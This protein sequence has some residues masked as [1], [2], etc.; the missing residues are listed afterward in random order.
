MAG[1]LHW[2]QPDAMAT[3]RR[4]VKRAE[5]QAWEVEFNRHLLAPQPDFGA[6][7]HALRN[8]RREEG[9]WFS[10]RTLARLLCVKYNTLKDPPSTEDEIMTII[11]GRI[12]HWRQMRARAAKS[13]ETQA[14]RRAPP[15]H[16]VAGTCIVPLTRPVKCPECREM[17]M[18]S[19]VRDSLYTSFTCPICLD[20]YEKQN[21]F[22]RFNCKHV[23]CSACF[24]KLRS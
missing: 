18:E 12:D 21:P 5:L 23:V 11:R 2:S 10:R 14:A 16:A 13:A 24:D 1:P 22:I 8:A 9:Q 4:L 19:V 17:H 3:K 20:E 15:R 7:E 6:A